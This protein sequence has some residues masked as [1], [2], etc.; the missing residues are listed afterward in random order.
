MS[1]KACVAGAMKIAKLQALRDEEVE[2]VVAAA[3]ALVM[4]ECGSHHDDLT[5]LAYHP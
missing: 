4:E 5:V 1:S 3:A 2:E